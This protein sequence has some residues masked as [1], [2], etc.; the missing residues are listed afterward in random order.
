MIDRLRSVIMDQEIAPVPL[1]R[2]TTPTDL[3]LRGWGSDMPY[4]DAA[5]ACPNCETV[6][7]KVAIEPRPDESRAEAV[8]RSLFGEYFTDGNGEFEAYCVDCDIGFYRFTTPVYNCKAAEWDG[9]PYYPYSLGDLPHSERGD[10]GEYHALILNKSLH[11]GGNWYSEP[12]TLEHHFTVDFGREC[13]LCGI[14]AA[15]HEEL[16]YH[17]WSYDPEIGVSLCR[18][19]HTTIH[20]DRRAVDQAALSPTGEW[21]DDAFAELVRKHRRVR[22]GD[23]PQDDLE[24]FEAIAVRYNIPFPSDRIERA[25]KRK[26]AYC[27][28]EVAR[29]DGR[30]D[31]CET[32]LFEP[33]GGDTGMDEDEIL[34]IAKHVCDPAPD[35]DPDADPV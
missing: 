6:L 34:K 31:H 14:P 12:G 22:T 19:C 3:A 5:L 10:P 27:D 8:Q 23:F 28:H 32:I 29:A 17:H 30:C 15:D 33:Y 7:N 35:L 26:F 20:N 13:P 24:D 4:Y 16:D 18:D 11:E 21:R 9:R 25:Y 2:I 1:G